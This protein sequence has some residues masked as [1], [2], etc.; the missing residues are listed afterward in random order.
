ME[1]YKKEVKDE[2]GNV[3]GYKEIPLFFDV[4]VRDRHNWDHKTNI[5]N[6]FVYD[7]RKFITLNLY[8]TNEIITVEGSKEPV[9]VE[10][11]VSIKDG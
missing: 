11:E 1:K 4:V 7:A 9:L 10:S 5:L 2:V 8:D 6:S 3:V